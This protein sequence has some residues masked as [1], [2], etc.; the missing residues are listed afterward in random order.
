[1]SRMP[2][3]DRAGG[4][5]LPSLWFRVPEPR[6]HAQAELRVPLDRARLLRR[7]R[8]DGHRPGLGC[9]SGGW[10]GPFPTR[11]TCWFRASHSVGRGARTL[12][13]CRSIP[14]VLRVQLRGGAYRASH[15]RAR[16][17]V[18]LRPTR[19]GVSDS[20]L[21]SNRS[22]DGRDARPAR[23]G[24]AS[25]RALARALS[26]PLEPAP[27]PHRGRGSDVMRKGA[28]SGTRGATSGLV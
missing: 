18:D 11:R 12:W 10:G 27:D 8:A 23:C 22:R 17:V 4:G 28:V 7:A 24:G 2:E 25:A 6:S 20:G 21:G 1:V 5:H 14:F 13:T 16:L 19:G 26:E 9:A 15:G 3:D